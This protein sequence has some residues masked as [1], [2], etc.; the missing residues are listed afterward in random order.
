MVDISAP[1]SKISYGVELRRRFYEVI[2]KMHVSR[3][4]DADFSGKGMR[5]RTRYVAPVHD[6]EDILKCLE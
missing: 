4:I 3:L 6:P 2:E 5:G 1:H